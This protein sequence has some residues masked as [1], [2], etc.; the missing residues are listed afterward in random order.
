MTKYGIFKCKDCMQVFT[1]KLRDNNIVRCP[2]VTHS[3]GGGW[4]VE[5]IGQG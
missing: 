5:Y 1:T 4:N 2:S 3:H